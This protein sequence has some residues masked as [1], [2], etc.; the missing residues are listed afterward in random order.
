MP[1]NIL[2]ELKTGELVELVVW[3]LDTKIKKFGGKYH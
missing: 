3:I 1:Y 2:Q